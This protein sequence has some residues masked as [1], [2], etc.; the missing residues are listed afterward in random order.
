MYTV[1]GEPEAVFVAAAAA[2]V[3]EDVALAALELVELLELPHA[4]R[5]S[6]AMI[7]G[8]TRY[9]RGP[10]QLAPMLLCDGTCQ[11]S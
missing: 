7:A 4:A 10:R 9:H 5:A 6:A 1:R 3:L 8:A 11:T 2:F